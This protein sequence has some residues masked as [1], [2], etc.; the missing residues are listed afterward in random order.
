MGLYNN[1]S[2]N[3]GQ[4]GQCAGQEEQVVP[5][6][7]SFPLVFLSARAADTRPVDAR[8]ADGGAADVEAADNREADTREANVR[9]AN[10][11]ENSSKIS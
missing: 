7:P 5:S 2:Q 11:L 9:E 3:L 6:M 4:Y 8:A 1:F 10:A